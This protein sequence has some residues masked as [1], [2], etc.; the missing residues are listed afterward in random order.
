MI[1]EA[2]EF[3]LK[4]LQLAQE[5]WNQLESNPRISGPWKQLFDQVKSPRHVLSELLQNA[6]DAG[7]NE[8]SAFVK[9]NTFFFIHNGDDFTDDNFSSLCRFALSNKR[10]LHTIGFRGI[11]FKSIFSLGDTVE[12]RTPTLAFAY[13]E[14]R[15]TE[16]IWLGEGFTSGKTEIRIKIKDKERVKAL[17][18]EF[19][20]WIHSPIPLLF[21]R[22]IQTLSIDDQKIHK[23]IINKGPVPNSEYIELT[24]HEVRNVLVIRS[25]LEDFPYECIEEIRKV[26]GSTDDKDFFMP[27]CS[28]QLV[29]DKSSKISR[30]YTVLPTNIKLELPF[31]INAPFIQDPSRNKIED[32]STS[33]TNRWLLGRLGRLAAFSM[34]DWLHNESISIEEKAA[35]YSLLPDEISV[36][37][38][39]EDI[40]SIKVINEFDSFLKKNPQ[41]M[42]G[43]DGSLTTFDKIVDLPKAIIK[44]WDYPDAL[45]FF[46]P[47]SDY[48]FA[49]Q[50]APHARRILVKKYGV[51]SLDIEKIANKLLY[52]LPPKPQP[53]EKI[54]WLW[55]YLKPLYQD[56]NWRYKDNKIFRIGIVPVA[57]KSKLYPV[58][59]VIALS[60]KT[61][62][63]KDDEIFLKE[64][65]NIVSPKWIN[66]LKQPD[67]NIH[68][69]HDVISNAKSF[70]NEL[71]L[72]KMV[73]IEQIISKA[74]E[75][76]FPICSDENHMNGIKLA[77]LASKYDV[78]VIDSF[79][80]LCMDG[81]WKY[82]R[83]KI[84]FSN[85]NNLEELLPKNIFMRN[86]LSEEY[87]CHFKED[88]AKIWKAWINDSTKSRI[89]GFLIPENKKEDLFIDEKNINELSVSRGGNNNLTLTNVL[90]KCFRVHDSDWSDDVIQYW[91]TSL[92]NNQ[93]IWKE[94][95]YSVLTNWSHEWKTKSNASLHEVGK[96]GG[97]RL[98]EN[99]GTLRANWLQRFRNIA[100]LPDSFGK[101]ACPV[102]L[103]RRTHDTQGL[104]N[105]ERF[106]HPDLDKP[107]Y[108]EALDLLGVI[109]SPI[110][111][112]PIISRL[113]NLSRSSNPPIF[114]LVEL[115]R[116][117]DRMLLRLDMEYTEKI[118]EI[119]ISEK[120]IYT[121]EKT[122]DTLRN[123]FLEN[124]DGIPGISIIHEEVGEI[125]LW[126][127]IGIQRY[128]SIENS[129]A[130]LKKIEIGTQLNQNDKKRAVQIL[131]FA[132]IKTWRECNAWIDASGRWVESTSF[133]WAS[134]NWDI[135]SKLYTNIKMSIADFSFLQPSSELILSE[136]RLGNIDSVLKMVIISHRKLDNAVYPDWLGVIADIISRIRQPQDYQDAELNN[137]YDDLEQSKILNRV[138][139]QRV[140]S[141]K[142]APYLDGMQVGGETSVK[143]SW[144][145]NTIY[146]TG[147]SAHHYKELVQEIC[148]HFNSREIRNFISVCIGRDSSWIE[149]YAEENL[150]LS[151]EQIDISTENNK[152]DEQ[153]H[154]EQETEEIIIEEQEETEDSDEKEDEEDYE[155]NRKKKKKK[156]RL[157]PTI[158]YLERTGFEVSED[159][160]TIKNGDGMTVIAADHGSPFKYTCFNSSGNIVSGYVEI[161]G[162]LEAG[163]EIPLNIWNFE[164]SETFDVN[165]ILYD[166][167]T[168][169]PLTLSNLKE[170]VRIG[171][172]EHFQSKMYLKQRNE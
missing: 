164:F 99:Q 59:K 6:E 24:N 17:K 138:C 14:K 119:F 18:E 7:A 32:P 114:H 129:I 144:T 37:S 60:E 109:N 133:K 124:P 162:S 33:P 151:D 122:W 91:E 46:S 143:V 146:V 134:F 88:F 132:P 67:E 108:I 158:E 43:H 53:L 20:K 4:A 83:D 15:F 139:I 3:F 145:D 127:R 152:K 75:I 93:E 27:P 106:I 95:A 45:K 160:T 36:S 57:G 126:S 5:D 22:F 102:Q 16:P 82:A 1:K 21:F 25:E 77:I 142:I 84:L 65:I 116:I 169:R 166:G 79:Q 62:L 154:E 159:G 19:Q 61:G 123:V 105:I 113:R 115:Y 49:D 131:Q 35:S 48:I 149:E 86:V 148:R 118:C 136:S 167:R 172:V 73:G 94:V 81:K 101:L 41:F 161:R 44:T 165:I 140:D 34:H 40:C 13:N 90:R 120:L 147:S 76:I 72:D 80:Y 56:W 104:E 74:A 50:I 97:E 155:N 31:S 54:A 8:V 28:V 51:E 2:P 68:D 71:G 29:L 130:W 163:F 157:N 63:E 110:G 135:I 171:E 141:L 117:I 168:I 52:K 85:K 111:I 23:K 96:R 58:N 12:I 103:Y 10:H 92:A 98:I 137:Y 100:C 38:D 78:R 107:Q 55:E 64:W 89:R 26:R 125:P 70:L 39:L 128:P 112:D 42:L 30:L 156:E 9:D 170:K 11:G 66:L 121:A 47:N 153:H 69:M 87:S 150:D